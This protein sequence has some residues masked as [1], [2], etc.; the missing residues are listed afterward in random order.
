MSKDVT[1][2][3]S[4]KEFNTQ[5]NFSKRTDDK[6]N[7]DLSQPTFVQNVISVKDVKTKTKFNNFR[8]GKLENGDDEKQLNNSA[9]NALEKLNSIPDELIIDFIDNVNSTYASPGYNKQK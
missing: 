9:A 3:Q 6:T 2:L 1:S 7:Y 8:L 5:Y 4:S